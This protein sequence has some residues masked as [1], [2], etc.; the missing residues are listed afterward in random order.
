[1]HTELHT[2]D[3]LTAHLAAGAPTDG[4]IIQNLDLRDFAP[5]AGLPS[6]RGITFLG[7]R[8]DPAVKLR[9][10]DTGALIFPALPD[11][12]F[13]PYRST[14][15]T[16][17][18]LMAGYDPSD[19]RSFFER[20]ADARIYAFYTA[21]H[22]AERGLVLDALA[23]RLH[24]HAIDDAL[25]DLLGR[26]PDPAR[27]KRVVA[28]MGGHGLGRD[29]PAYRDVAKLAAELTRQGYF[30][31]SGGGPGAMEATHLGAWF[32]A[33]PS[34]LEAALTLL[35]SAPKYTDPDWFST[36]YAARSLAPCAADSLAIPT[37]FYGH[38]PT[39][40]FA[41][42]VAKYFSNSL[43]EDGLLMIATHGVIYARGMAGTVQEIFMD[44]CQNHYVTPGLISPMVFLDR[45]YWTETLP[46]VPLLRALAGTR[47]YAELVHVTDDPQDAA[48]FILEHP[49]RKA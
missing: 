7:C 20:T 17:D 1:M 14:L 38:E 37:W 9:A 32:S 11:L 47:P 12:P 15:Y 28:I 45:A 6:F 23:Q 31:A 48:R 46:A 30:M 42:H 18:E 39:N 26:D 24:D 8:L 44:A 35:A 5:I 13:L 36:A 29:T 49:P 34:A 25:A 3:A 41:S 10:V 22:G 19:P 21:H 40:L 33:D 2:L 43:R 16:V 27:R 4:L